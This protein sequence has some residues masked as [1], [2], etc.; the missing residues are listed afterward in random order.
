MIAEFLETIKENLFLIS[1]IV[2]V[3]LLSFQLGRI[4]KDAGQPIQLDKASIQEIFNSDSNLRITSESTNEKKNGGEER[5]D[6]RVVVSKKSTSG[7]YHFLWCA[8]AKQIKEEN[9]IY[10]NS[11]EE[12]STAGYSLAGNCSK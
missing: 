2:L 11:E 12:A 3:A 10:F 1:L 6:F 4:S 5:I 7:K 8:G 9:K